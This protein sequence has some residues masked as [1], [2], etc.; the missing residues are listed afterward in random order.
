MIKQ[1]RLICL[2]VIYTILLTFIRIAPAQENQTPETVELKKGLLFRLREGEGKAVKA[3]TS[4]NPRSEKLSAAE[5]EA[6]FRRLPPMLEETG[7]KTDFALRANNLPPPKTGKIIPLKF[8]AD[9]RQ[10]PN[11]SNTAA[12]EIMSAAPR[13]FVAMV[14]DLSVTFSQPMIAVS[15]Q[16]EVSTESV[17]VR[18]TPE[19]K[20]KWRWR[21]AN[22]LVFVAEPRFPP[23]TTFRAT[24]PAGTKSVTG[25]V[26]EKDFSWNFETPPAKVESFSPKDET[27]GRDALML[28]G[29]NQQINPEA[30]LPKISAATTAPNGQKIALRLATQAEIE[31]DKKLFEKVKKLPAKNW[32][33]FRAVDPLPLDS[34]IKVNFEAGIASAEGALTSVLPFNFAFKTYGNFNFAESACG[35]DDKKSDCAYYDD[36]QIEFSNPVDAENFDKSLVKIEPQF[37]DAEIAVDGDQITIGGCCRRHRETYKVTVSERLRDIY[38][39]TLGKNVSAKFKIAA[40]EPQLYFEKP[41]NSFVTLDPSTR[42][43]VLSVYSNGYP[44]LRVKIY[45]VKPE[46]YEVFQRAKDKNRESFNIEFPAIGK[47]VS[48]KTIKIK[49]KRDVSTETKINF[50]P[51]FVNNLGHAVLVVEPPVVTEENEDQRIFLWVEAT[52]I[53]V[54]AFADYEKLTVYASDLKTGKALKDVSLQSSEGARGVTS[55]IG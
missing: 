4:E 43:P 16:N 28:A 8:P 21:G 30:V 13:G 35:Y 45:A 33:A 48:D 19:I 17:P 39:Q 22:T 18:V 27:V 53:G 24:I 29:F 7:D 1:N 38:G 12:L 2:V 3:E 36:F 50:S 9:E 6:I 31:A 34:Q 32:I 40:L 41:D 14:K 49:G 44:N 23:A 42:Q 55:E 52:Q 26:L 51:A 47:L 54:D 10:S 5:A 46:D 25:A 11:V 37:K 20:G 15:S